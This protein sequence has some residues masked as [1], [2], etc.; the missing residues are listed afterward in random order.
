MPEPVEM[1]ST[2]SCYMRCARRCVGVLHGCLPCPAHVGVSGSVASLV[3]SSTVASSTCR[4][5]SSGVSA[6]SVLRAAL[7]V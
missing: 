2:I 6:G 3:P 7:E 4:C 1:G 5:V